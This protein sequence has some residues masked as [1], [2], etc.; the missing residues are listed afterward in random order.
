MFCA[1][2]TNNFVMIERIERAIE[3]GLRPVRRKDLE[4]GPNNFVMKEKDVKYV[5]VRVSRCRKPFSVG[6]SGNRGKVE[7]ALKNSLTL[8]PAGLIDLSYP[9][10]RP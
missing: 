1:K 7:E 8:R 4:G 5:G 10:K 6:I 9:L 3:T 2:R